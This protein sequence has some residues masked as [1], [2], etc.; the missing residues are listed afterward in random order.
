MYGGKSEV[1]RLRERILL[2]SQA[3]WWALHGL[4]SGNAQ[5]E[6]ITARLKKM[7][8]YHGHLAVLVGEEQAT[9]YLCEAFEE[10][11]HER[12]GK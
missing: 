8:E 2:E 3:S 7:G 9:D 11:K 5:H 10:G 4:S 12:I 6:F 1:A